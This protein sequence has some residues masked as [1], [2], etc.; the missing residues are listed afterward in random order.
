MRS[1]VETLNPSFFDRLSPGDVLFIDGSHRTLMNSDVTMLWL[2]VL[3]RLKPG[4]IVHLHDVFLPYD[5]PP[6]WASRYYSEQYLLAASLLA[7]SPM[8]ILF[9]SHF[10][11]RDVVLS[12][13]LNVLWESL[14][15]DPQLRVGGSFWFKT[16]KVPLPGR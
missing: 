5:Y 15:L 14:G 4:V 8:E 7:G 12:S 1:R 6:E 13:R 3:P 2:D 16:R 11:Q 9:P 10:V